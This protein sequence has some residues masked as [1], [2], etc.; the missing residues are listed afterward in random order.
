M[1]SAS[2]LDLD[3]EKA[4]RSM[5]LSWVSTEQLNTIVSR[6]RVTSTLNFSS[7]VKYF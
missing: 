3:S 2:C 4:E 7:R 6:F 5:K 1:Q